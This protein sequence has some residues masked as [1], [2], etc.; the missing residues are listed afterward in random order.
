MRPAPRHQIN[1][2]SLFSALITLLMSR[3]MHEI[4]RVLGTAKKAA[5]HSGVMVSRKFLSHSSSNHLRIRSL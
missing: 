1:M 3:S 4:S 2:Q 5:Q